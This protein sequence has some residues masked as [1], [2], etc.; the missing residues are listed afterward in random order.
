LTKRGGRAAEYGPRAAG[1]G[2]EALL[3][4]RKR[5]PDAQGRRTNG[6]AVP[7]PARAIAEAWIPRF[8]T[9][10]LTKRRRRC[11][12]ITAQGHYEVEEA[13]YAE[14]YVW[15]PGEEV[16]GRAIEEVLHPWRAGYERWLEDRELHPELQEWLEIRALS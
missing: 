14:N 7:E 16:E 10:P 12:M 2:N 9:E 8:S 11:A 3:R 13:A 4:G 5:K 15:M 6:K 1:T